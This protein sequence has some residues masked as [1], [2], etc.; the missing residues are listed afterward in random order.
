MRIGVEERCW[1][2]LGGGRPRAGAGG[3]GPFGGEEAK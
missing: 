1:L 3:G 2:R